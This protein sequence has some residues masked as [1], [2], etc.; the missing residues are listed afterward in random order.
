MFSGRLEARSPSKR[1][2]VPL[3]AWDRPPRT[4]RTVWSRPPRADWRS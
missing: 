3:K 4:V 1:W 2:R